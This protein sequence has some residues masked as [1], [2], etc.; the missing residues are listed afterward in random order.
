MKA[1]VLAGGYP[2]IALINELKSRGYTVLLADYYPNPIA[3]E[4]ADEFYQVSTLDVEAVTE[5]ARREK[6]DF[7]ITA[8]T[9]Q[10]LHT[11]ALVSERL[12]LPCYIDHQ[13]ALNVTNKRYMKQVFAESG[14][15]TAKHCVM[16]ELN[17]ELLAEME[18]PLIV[19]PADANSSK[20]VIKVRCEDELEEAFAESI[21]FSRTSTAVVEEFVE[22]Q[23]ITVDVQVTDGK[24]VVLSK[25]Y[26][27]K[28]ADDE[29]FVIYR[30]RFPVCEPDTVHQQ[31]QDAAQR[32][33]DAFGLKNSLMLIQL[34]SNG[35]RIFVLEF[36]A[37]TGGGVKFELIK[38]V[39][40][41]DVISAVVDLTLGKKPAVE[42][43]DPV[44][45]YITNTFIYCKPGV[46]DHLEGFEEL[47]QEG[48][49][50]SYC[51]FK[52]RGAKFEKV[53]SSGDR[54]GCFTVI[55]DTLEQ[56]KKKYNTAVERIRVMDTEGN[57]MIRRDLLGELYYEN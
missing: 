37:R 1:L 15:P 13:T 10:A 12:G 46:Y 14:V 56:Q 55:S 17:K 2:Q 5:L 29:R 27:D 16:T 35:K 19:K 47:K 30:T 24:A 57:D 36:S 53:E 54:V 40:G 31:I 21:G 38:N 39:C 25:A 51:V 32:I 44:A 43:R 9:D 41:F 49:L 11:V 33:A 20:G 23:E 18:Y 28:I 26:S 4:Y 34:I 48:I 6:V 8:C 50:H 3:K 7:L 22:G 45:K 52:W 42:L